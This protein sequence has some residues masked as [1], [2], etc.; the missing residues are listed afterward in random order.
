MASFAVGVAA[1]GV[2]DVAL[3][4]RPEDRFDGRPFFGARG[5]TPRLHIHAFLPRLAAGSSE[6]VA[7]RADADV[8]ARGPRAPGAGEIRQSETLPILA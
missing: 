8:W 5:S 1:G 7:D 2:V 4:R 3:G 6:Q